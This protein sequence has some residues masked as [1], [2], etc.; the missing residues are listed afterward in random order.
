MK[1][2]YKRK[3]NLIGQVLRGDRLLRDVLEGRMMGKRVRDRPRIA[4]LNEQ[5]E[6]SFVKMN[7]R[8]ET[9]EAWKEFVPRTCRKA[10]H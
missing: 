3:K 5:M 10:E 9:R 4:M 1:T 6:G 2:V 8:A 7:R